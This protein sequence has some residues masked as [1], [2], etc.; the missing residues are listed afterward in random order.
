MAYPFNIVRAKTAY[1]DTIIKGT[2]TDSLRNKP[3]VMDFDTKKEYA[4]DPSTLTFNTGL[5][6]HD[7]NEIF[8]GDLLRHFS[9]PSKQRWLVQAEFLVNKGAFFLRHTE[10]QDFYSTAYG[11]TH[12]R[13]VERTDVVHERLDET[14]ACQYIIVGNIYEG[15][16][17]DN[18]SR[19][20]V[21]EHGND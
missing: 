9:D 6:D 2:F 3:F 7:D 14:L 12:D 20:K 19:D 18:P 5:F 1:E 21:F 13:F 4:V 11:P 8:T 16:K 17:D 10:R 15:A